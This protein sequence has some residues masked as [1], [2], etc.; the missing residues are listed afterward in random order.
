MPKEETIG[1]GKIKG[2]EYKELVAFLSV[3]FEAINDQFAE[4]NRQLDQK[5]DK[6]EVE[7][8]IN[9]VNGRIARLSDKIDDYNAE[10]IGM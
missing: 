9:G 5:A 4:V 7:K 6:T 8:M 2:N 10:Q 1:N 3:K